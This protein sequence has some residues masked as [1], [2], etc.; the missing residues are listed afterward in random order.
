MEVERRYLRGESITQIATAVGAK[1]A[2]VARDLQV[3]AGVWRAHLNLRAERHLLLEEVKQVK[4][5]AWALFAAVPEENVNGKLGALSAVLKASVRHVEVLGLI[6][7][8]AL[9]DQLRDAQLH[10]RDGRCETSQTT[11]V[12]RL[13][14]QVRKPTR[15]HLAD[16]PQELPIRRDPH[17][18]LRH[19]QRHQFRVGDLATRA[20]ARDRRPI[21]E[22]VR[23][24][25]KGLQ[26]CCHLVLQSR[27]NRAGGPFFVHPPG[28][29]S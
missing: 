13:L 27:G 22:H 28:P 7:T 10:G 20:T 21:R 15:Q 4:L 18:C 11:V 29:C 3:L 24:Y 16:Q 8:G 23:G 14:G 9:G 19:R 25:N 6:E 12:L 1:R 17:R 26:R 2:T 5:A